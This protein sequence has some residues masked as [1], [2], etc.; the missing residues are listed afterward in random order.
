MKREGAGRG[1]RAESRHPVLLTPGG[2]G[3]W[4]VIS[5]C[6]ECEHAQAYDR[7]RAFRQDVFYGEQFGA[8]L[9]GGAPLLAV[10]AAELREPVS[11]TPGLSPLRWL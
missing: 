8:L 9:G 6:W 3:S 4:A 11:V 2:A 7:H 1:H 10:G 5:V